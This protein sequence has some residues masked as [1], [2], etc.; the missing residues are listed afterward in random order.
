MNKKQKNEVENTEIM[1][2]DRNGTFPMSSQNLKNQKFVLWFSS[3]KNESD[4]K[5]SGLVLT[6]LLHHLDHN[7]CNR[8]EGGLGLGETEHLR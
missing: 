5:K 6:P 3:V 4:P 8:A 1:I 7:I 2:W